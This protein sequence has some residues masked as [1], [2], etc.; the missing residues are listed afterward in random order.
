MERARTT[1]V[2]ILV[3]TESLSD[4]ERLVKQLAQCALSVQ[5]RDQLPY[6]ST[7]TARAT[8]TRDKLTP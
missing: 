8:M 3:N 1:T 4:Q 2:L 7:L 5:R 6:L